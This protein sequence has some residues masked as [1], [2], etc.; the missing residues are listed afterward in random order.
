LSRPQVW[1]FGL[2]ER[3]DSRANK[4]CLFIV[5]PKRDAFTLLD[6]IYQ[7]CLENTIIHSDCWQAYSQ[8]RQLDKS[9]LHKSVNHDLHFVDPVTRVHTNSIESMWR[10]AK[11]GIDKNK[12][13]SREY[14]Q[15]YLDEFCWRH[16][17]QVGRTGNFRW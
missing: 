12:G 11:D 4:R 1:V 16:N 5:V 13:V 3:D 14:L 8:I 15:S 2:Y 6:L 10:Q 17:N 7:Y 9:F